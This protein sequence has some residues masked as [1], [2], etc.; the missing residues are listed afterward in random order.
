MSRGRRGSQLWKVAGRRVGRVDGALLCIIFEIL[1]FA[2]EIEYE[3]GREGLPS[4][5][6]TD[7]SGLASS[8]PQ[9]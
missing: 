7:P 6:G 8:D 9:G 3:Q 1:V 4:T 2:H 5:I